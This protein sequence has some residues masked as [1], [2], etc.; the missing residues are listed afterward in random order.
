[1]IVLFP[2]TISKPLQVFLFAFVVA[3][4]K[5][6]QGHARNLLIN[7]HNDNMLFTA[8]GDQAVIGPDK[9]RITGIPTTATCCFLGNIA[10]LLAEMFFHIWNNIDNRCE[11]NSSN[12][13]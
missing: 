4:S 11:L 9:L 8:D 7:S 6:A 3:G 2:C 5:E 12:L 13:V 1:M 10:H